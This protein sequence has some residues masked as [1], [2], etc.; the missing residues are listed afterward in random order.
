MVHWIEVAA[1]DAAVHLPDHP[2]LMNFLS[3]C[4]PGAKWL[5]VQSSTKMKVEDTGDLARYG[6][7]SKSVET[8]LSAGWLLKKT[9]DLRDVHDPMIMNT[10]LF[11]A[12]LTSADFDFGGW[13]FS[14]A[15]LD[16]TTPR[17]C[18]LVV[19][20]CGNLGRTGVIARLGCSGECLCQGEDVFGFRLG[21]VH[22]VDV[23]HTE[24]PFELPATGPVVVASPKI[25]PIQIVPEMVTVDC[26]ASPWGLGIRFREL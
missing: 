18:R 19:P 16:R 2:D 11:L 3:L 4:T 8:L 12:E 24:S 20:I 9:A 22:R 5:E 25:E 6:Y 14:T 1:G 26:D 7:F 23:Q 13:G 21:R 15:D 10:L 17:A